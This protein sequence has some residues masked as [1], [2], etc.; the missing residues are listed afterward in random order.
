MPTRSEPREEKVDPAVAEDHAKDETGLEGPEE[1]LPDEESP[2]PGPSKPSPLPSKK[3]RK[4][5]RVDVDSSFARG[6]DFTSASTVINF[7]LPPTSTGYL[8]RVGRTARAGHSGMALSFVVS[9]QLHERDIKS[10][11]KSG[12]ASDGS[13][14]DQEV[15]AEITKV[16]AGDVQEWDWGSRKG[17]IDGFR[18]RMEDALRAVTS[19]RVEEARREEVRKELINSEKL[20]ASGLVP[21]SAYHQA[22]FAANP[23]DLAYLRHDQPSHPARHQPH[24]KHIPNYL[25]PKIA[26]AITGNGSSADTLDHR[27]IGFKR[28]RGQGRGG[29]RGRGGKRKVNPLR[30]K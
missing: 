14:R 3:S 12:I 26:G 6:I 19:K 20:K 23:L 16:A 15:F 17:E 25:M 10:A 11:R 22:H 28:E 24:L 2:A 18:Y 27:H 9:R 4:R 5:R 7:D 1:A 29:G 13:E 21:S 8:H 30:F